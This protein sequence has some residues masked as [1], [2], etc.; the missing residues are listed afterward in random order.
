MTNVA[1]ATES[2]VI[3]AGVRFLPSC[4]TQPDNGCNIELSK[5]KSRHAAPASQILQRF[6]AAHRLALRGTDGEFAAADPDHS[7][8]RLKAMSRILHYG[9]Q[10]EAWLAT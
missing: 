7:R 8:R 1:D 9:R 4:E 6:P 2:D 5:G 3:A 10:R